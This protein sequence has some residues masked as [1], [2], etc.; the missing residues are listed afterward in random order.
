MILKHESSE[1]NTDS[2]DQGHEDVV[3]NKLHESLG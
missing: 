2:E 3:A 1:S